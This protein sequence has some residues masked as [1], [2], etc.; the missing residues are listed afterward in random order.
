M[1]TLPYKKLASAAAAGAL[2]LAALVVPTDAAT[3]VSQSTAQAVN[4]ALLGT[5]AVAASNPPTSASSDGTGGTVTNTAGPPITVLGSETFLTAGA[6]SETATAEPSGTSYACAGIVQSGAVVQVGANGTSC[7]SSGG[8]GTGLTLNLGNIPGVGSALNGIAGITIN[9]GAATSFATEGPTGTATGSATLTNVTA[10]ITPLGLPAITVPLNISGAVDENVL[11]ALV[12]ALSSNP[13]Y[14]ALATT[15]STALSPVLSLETNYQ[16][17]PTTG[18]LTVSAL[19]IAVLGGGASTADLA[20]VTVGPNA[21]PAAGPI[22]SLRALPITLGTA[23]FVV[24]VVATVVLFRRRRT[25]DE[26]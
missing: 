24:L 11:T 3:V 25:S 5:P 22:T 23:G 21:Q 18:E 9:A 6:L 19:H 4:I 17:T 7:S 15:I 1:I 13:L 20:K 26:R 10:T 16:T 2:L 8:S 12:T 14:A